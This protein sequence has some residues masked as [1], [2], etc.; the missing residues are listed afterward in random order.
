M[1]INWLQLQPLKPKNNRMSSTY[2]VAIDGNEA[3]TTQRVGSNV[4]AFELI[5]A[6]YQQIERRDL[7]AT[8]LLSSPPLPHWPAETDRWHYQLVKPARYWTQWAAPIYLEK[9]KAEFD[10]FFTPSHYAPRACP[11]PYVSSV[12]DTAYIA[13]PNEFKLKDRL[14]L[15]DWTEY[16]VKNADQVVVI[17]RFTKRSVHEVYK[18]PDKKIH[19]AYPAA[20]GDH[21]RV[22]A[23]EKKAYLEAQ[24]IT[25]P[26]FVYVGT[27][28]PRKR[29]TILIKAFEDVCAEITAA[30]GRYRPK[31][32]AL[33]AL[34]QL[35]IAGKIGW[36]ANS[37]IQRAEQSPFKKQ[38]K[39]LGYVSDR[40]K[41]ILLQE[42]KALVLIGRHEGF[43]IPPLE[44][45]LAGT[46]PIVA[47]TGS[48]PEVVGQAGML[49]AAD[50]TLQ[51]ANKLKLVLKQSARERALLLAK[52]RDQAKTFSWTNSADVI[53]E[54]LDLVVAENNH[55]SQ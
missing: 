51:L 14:Q 17:S 24:G 49:V 3:N 36:L 52:G 11:I 18:V 43:G 47:R 45:M 33:N 27:I 31:K 4:Y 2:H 55:A 46:I 54:A 35:I 44:A 19:I 6:M 26:F 32:S 21:E 50:D 5:Q 42:S 16:S 39:L 7:Q 12:M 13:Y 10:V 53:F 8:V 28:Q 38:I 41:T 37:V 30:S 9:H 34:P 29:L 22:P 48:L 40:D 23:A 15:T 25:T 1:C 20:A